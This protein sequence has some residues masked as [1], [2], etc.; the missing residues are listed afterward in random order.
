MWGSWRCLDVMPS[1]VYYPCK[2]E[3]DPCRVPQPAS[4]SPPPTGA[5]TRV[6]TNTDRHAHTHTRAHARV[7]VR[8]HARAHTR[9]SVWPSSSPRSWTLTVSWPQSCRDSIP[10]L[11]FPPRPTRASLG[12]AF[13][14][15][16]AARLPGDRRAGKRQ[17]QGSPGRGSVL[18]KMPVSLGGGSHDNLTTSVQKSHLE[19]FSVPD[20]PIHQGWLPPQS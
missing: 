1:W 8:T 7:H 10:V 17:G 20:T 4:L 5:D 11:F 12:P 2:H 3:P 19:E 18:L 13:L 15:G 14:E 16:K 6:C 9:I